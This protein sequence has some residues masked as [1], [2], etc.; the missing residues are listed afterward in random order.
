MP[1][2]R[3]SLLTNHALVLVHVVDR[4]RSTLREIADNVGI[5]DRAALAI[6]RDMEGDS[7]V[8]RR[9]DGRRNVYTVDMEAL[10][11]YREYGRFSLTQIASALFALSGRDP[12][13]ELPPNLQSPG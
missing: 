13:S 4:P 1:E 5:T 9:K 11:T 2:R 7:I 3:W 8:T 10:I 12:G 6:L